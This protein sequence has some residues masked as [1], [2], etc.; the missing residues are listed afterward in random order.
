MNRLA[1]IEAALR[2]LAAA[3]DDEDW[4]AMAAVPT[5]APDDRRPDDSIDHAA[6]Q[7]LL[8]DVNDLLAALTAEAQRVRS[9]LET[10]PRLRRAARAYLT[11]SPA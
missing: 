1:R 5:F 10:Q 4:L 11:S 6:A 3:F 7:R 9:E 8:R 2:D